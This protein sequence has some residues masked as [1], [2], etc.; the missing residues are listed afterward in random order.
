LPPTDNRT[1]LGLRREWQH[2]SLHPIQPLDL[3]GESVV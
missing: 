1:G 2:P 3:L